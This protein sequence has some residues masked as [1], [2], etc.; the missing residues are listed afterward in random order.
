MDTD[1]IRPLT[2]ELKQLKKVE[3]LLSQDSK[4]AKLVGPDGKEMV[5]PMPVYETLRK[6][7]HFLAEGSA[8]SIVPEAHELSTQE[9]AEL[10]NVSRPFIVQLLEK[11][12]IPFHLVGSHRRIHF[13]DVIHYKKRRDQGRRK[14][15]KKI[16]AISED[17]GLYDSDNVKDNE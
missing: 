14:A 8:I 4:S 9:A 10:L 5:L 15:L 11:E 12:E 6:A 17:A 16:S 13:S 7:I 2:E 1:L 3:E